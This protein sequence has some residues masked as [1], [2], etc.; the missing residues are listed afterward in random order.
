MPRPSTYKQAT[1]AGLVFSLMLVA[2]WG[3][4]LR[5]GLIRAAA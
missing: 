1:L 2:L 4:L 5:S 3:S